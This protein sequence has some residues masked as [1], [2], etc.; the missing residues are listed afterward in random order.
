T[1]GCRMAG[2]APVPGLADFRRLFA[3]ALAGIEGEGWADALAIGAALPE[4]MLAPFLA[5]ARAARE[6]APCP[7]DAEL[8]RIYGTASL[9][10]VKRLL[11]YME[12]RGVIVVRTDLAGGR[13]IALPHLGWTTA[14]TEAGRAA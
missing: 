3:L 2:V 11:G 14:V 5:L 12:E 1:V 10:R 13:S 6:A 4:E 9:G 8:A 7:Q